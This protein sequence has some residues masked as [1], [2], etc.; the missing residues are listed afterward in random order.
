MNNILNVGEILYVKDG[1]KGNG[2]SHDKGKIVL[3][4]NKVKRGYAKI[5]KVLKEADNYYLAEDENIPYDYYDGMSYAEF[6]EMLVA[7]GYKIGYEQP[8][9]NEQHPELEQK[10]MFAY[11]MTNG[12][13]I[14]ADTYHEVEDDGMFNAINVYVPNVM[15]KYANIT[16]HGYKYNLSSFN[17]YTDYR[18]SF[19][20]NTLEEMQRMKG[21]NNQWS[22]NI[23]PHMWHYEEAETM[24][25]PYR[26][27]KLKEGKSYI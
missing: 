1:K 17:I 13:I 27:L 6:K 14:I 9:Y 18:N 15:S 22:E 3:F 20:L 24:K 7:R 19:S 26:T 10:H 5:T 23:L 21:G 8:F 16:Y 2:V 4:R 12:I 11:N 25:N